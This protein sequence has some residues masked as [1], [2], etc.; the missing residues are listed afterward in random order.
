MDLGA[1]AAA[2]VDVPADEPQVRWLKSHLKMPGYHDDHWL[3]EHDKIASSFISDKSQRKMFVFFHQKE[4][5]ITPSL[6]GLSATEI[7][8]IK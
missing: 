3:P 2:Y 7:N 8:N 6:Q 1:T 4:L 5:V